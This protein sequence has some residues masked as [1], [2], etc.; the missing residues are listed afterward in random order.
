[1]AIVKWLGNAEFTAAVG[2]TIGNIVGHLTACYSS[3]ELA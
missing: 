1:L 2:I 3:G